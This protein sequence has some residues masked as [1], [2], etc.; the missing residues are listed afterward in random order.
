VQ[1]EGAEK[2]AEIVI[3]NDSFNLLTDLQQGFWQ[4]LVDSAGASILSRMVNADCRAYILSESSLFVWRDRFIILTC[5]ETNLAK[6]VEFFVTNQPLLT[7]ASLTFQRKNEYFSEQQPSS[8]KQDIERLSRYIDGKHYIVGD[9]AQ[10][11]HQLL[12][13][14][15][16]R[17]H[18]TPQRYELLAFGIS[19]QASDFF[20]QNNITQGDVL[21]YLGLTEALGGYTLDSHHFS[22]CG[23]SL[24][25]INGEQYITLHITPQH[26]HSYVSLVSNSDIA[27][28]SNT[29]LSRLNPLCF[30]VLTI[31]SLDKSQQL[32]TFN[33][34]VTK[35]NHQSVL[36]AENRLLTYVNLKQQ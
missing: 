18:Q 6:A 35:L 36:I 1:F 32:P 11:H 25:A 5:G 7:I 29:L 26:A 30:D 9:L 33:D 16:D 22:P 12:S 13:Y 23:F 2:K 24:N 34:S 3:A 10:H 17:T 15:D 31:N 20:H 4:Q 8:F 19:H 14:H 21:G 28:L 27:K